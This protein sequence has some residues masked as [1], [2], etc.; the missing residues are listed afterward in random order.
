[1][2]R[3]WCYTRWF[4]SSATC[5]PHTTQIHRDRQGNRLQN[6]HPTPGAQYTGLYFQPSNTGLPG[7]PV[8]SSMSAPIR[9]PLHMHPPQPTSLA[10]LIS[11]MNPQAQE[12][13]MLWHAP[14]PLLLQSR[15]Q[16]AVPAHQK[17]LIASTSTPASTP[18]STLSPCTSSQQCSHEARG[19]YSRG[20][21]TSHVK[22]G[23][24]RPKWP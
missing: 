21:T 23:S 20:L 15:T 17:Q 2:H 1:M 14:T 3:Q 10:A 19:L 22:S 4:Q 6:L 7:F 12:E 18:C 13:H 24:S 8:L 16:H 9:T 11:H 5:T